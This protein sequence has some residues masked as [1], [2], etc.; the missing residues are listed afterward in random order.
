MLK[1]C[2][3]YAH[4]S[5][6]HRG[7]NCRLMQKHRSESTM[8]DEKFVVKVED[9]RRFVV[10]CMAAVGAKEEN[11]KKVADLL[12]AADQ[13]GHYS[14]GLNRLR[15]YMEDCR[16]GN[17]DPNAQPTILRQKGATAWIDGNNGLGA[18]VGDY[19]TRI[20]I[21]LAQ[22][23]GVGW[24]VAKGSNHF[25]IAGYWPILMKERGYL[26]IAMT[27]TSPLVFP[28]RASQL[29][30]GT[31]PIAIVAPANENDDF[32]LDMAT[33]AVALGKIELAERKGEKINE[34]W[35]ADSKGRNTD[36]PTEI[37]QQGG[38]LLPLGGSEETGGYK[39]FGLGMSIEVLSS[40]LA[41][42]TYG[43]NVRTWRETSKVADLGQTFIC[44]DPLCFAPNFN[45]RLQSY[46][47]E[48][49]RLIPIDRTKKVLIPGDPEREHLA[50][51]GIG[52]VYGQA[53]LDHL[54]DIAKQNNVNA[55]NYRNNNAK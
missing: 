47:D 42:A 53:Q 7:I 8:T 23:N 32:A 26:G 36:D 45:S 24:V 6:L 49:R 16:S 54:L 10:D 30:V 28:T 9:M 1:V 33:S 43:K 46:L 5:L 21:E 25:G 17:C 34:Q 19:C 29:A 14:H 15:I 50:E 31:N 11:G 2:R 37:T 48:T 27:N 40:I 35:G 51:S 13:R 44:I 22:Q 55:F 38:G 18:V 12:I 41:G 52:I 39:G 4:S 20:A 3:N